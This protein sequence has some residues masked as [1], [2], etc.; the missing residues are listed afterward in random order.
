MSG[1]SFLSIC[2]IFKNS[3]LSVLLKSPLKI[4]AVITLMKQ[5]TALNYLHSP[6]FLLVIFTYTE[7]PHIKHHPTVDLYALN[8]DEPECLS[9][10]HSETGNAQK[11]ITSLEAD[12]GAMNL[13]LFNEECI[14]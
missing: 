1:S 7:A 2:C 4:I 5:V 10:Q 8:I 11:L 12:L 3:R 13:P 6:R 14:C 9:T